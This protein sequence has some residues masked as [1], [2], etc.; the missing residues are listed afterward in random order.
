MKLR[1]QHE[2]GEIEVLSLVPPIEATEGHRQNHLR[3]GE[4]LEHYFTQDGFYDGWARN[5]SGMT[6]DEVAAKVAEIEKDRVIE[7]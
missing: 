2:S 6:D 5:T 4:G 3:S 1:V 7:A